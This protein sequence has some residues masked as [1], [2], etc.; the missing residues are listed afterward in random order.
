MEIKI[1]QIKH[2]FDGFFRSF[3]DVLYIFNIESN[4]K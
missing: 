3:E 2:T 1:A 4:N